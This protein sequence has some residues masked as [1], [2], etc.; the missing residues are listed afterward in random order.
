MRYQKVMRIGLV[1]VLQ[2]AMLF[3]MGCSSSAYICPLKDLPG[4][5]SS[6]WKAYQATLTHPHQMDKDSI[7]E[8]DEKNKKENVIYAY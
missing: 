3:M 7:F 5:C 2:I 6:Q 1:M 8:N 4:A